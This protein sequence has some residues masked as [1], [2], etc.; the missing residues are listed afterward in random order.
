MIVNTYT[1]NDILRMAG[2]SDGSQLK[3]R[4]IVKIVRETMNRMGYINYSEANRLIRNTQR[5]DY[6]NSSETLTYIETKVMSIP[7]LRM[8]NIKSQFSNKY[9]YNKN[10]IIIMVRALNDFINNH[11]NDM[12]LSAKACRIRNRE[13]PYRYNYGLISWPI[14]DK[15]KCLTDFLQ[16]QEYGN[17]V[18]M[19]KESE[20]VQ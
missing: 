12:D 18:K 2:Y 19:L 20:N 7:F 9:W 10:E 1:E 3:W 17:A 4:K 14:A 5:E 11:I 13:Y 16:S 15:R 8:V 6:I